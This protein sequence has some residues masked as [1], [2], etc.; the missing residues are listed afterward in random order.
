M[1]DDLGAAAERSGGLIVDDHTFMRSA[2]SACLT[3]LGISPIREAVSLA[4]GRSLLAEF[5]P[6]IAVVDLRLDDGSSLSLIQ[7][8][9]AEGVG[10]MVLTSA[11]DGYNVRS[12][13]AAGALG[14]LLKSAPHDTVMHGLREVLGGRI[15][16]DP[17]VAML[18]VQGVQEAPQT[19]GSSLTSREIEILQLVADGLSNADIGEQ[20]GLAPLSVKSHLT[21]IG[22]KLGTGDR[23]QMVAAAMR[24]DV[25]R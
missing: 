4:D 14:Y 22:R 19:D 1:S 9:K 18:L 23:T 6:R 8:L 3:E 21:R 15:Y 20:M 13:Y 5:T 10:V 25:L 2:M 7:M 12:A 17:T 16:A 24:A 11:D